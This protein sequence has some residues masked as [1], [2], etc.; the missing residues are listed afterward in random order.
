MKELTF[1]P[2]CAFLLFF[3]SSF[4]REEYLYGRGERERER[5]ITDR[6]LEGGRDR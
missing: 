2:L 5:E 3:H 6:K 4:A 1:F